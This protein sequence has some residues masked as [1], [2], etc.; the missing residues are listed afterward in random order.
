MPGSETLWIDGTDQTANQDYVMDV[1]AGLAYVT[2][3]ISSESVAKY[4]NYKVDGLY[5]TGINISK[6]GTAQVLTIPGKDT[7]DVL[8]EY[9]SGRLKPIDKDK[10][11]PG[12]TYIVNY[13]TEGEYVSNEPLQI[14]ASTDWVRTSKYPLKYQSVILS[15]NGVYIDE[16]VDFRISY[17]TGRI[18]FFQPLLPG[19]ILVVSYSPLIAH[20]NGL[21]NVYG[22]SYCT[23]YDATVAVASISPIAFEFPNSSVT[24]SAIP[25]SV[26]N[27][28]KAAYYDTTGYAF[29]AGNLQLV[30]DSTN[31]A[32]GTEFSDVVVMSYKFPS[33]GVEYAPVET[34]NFVMNQGS[35]FIALVNQ[36]ST[37]LFPSGT[38]VRLTNVDS[39]GDFYF[40]DA[41]AVYDGEDTLVYFYGTAPSDIINP[42]IYISD[43][44]TVLYISP[45]AVPNPITSG[46][47]DIIF[48]GS[49]IS[50]TF[51]SGQLMT[52]DS[53]IYSI[54]GSEYD[55]SARET[56]VTLGVQTYK[57]YT[58]AGI[59]S[60][61]TIS[62]IPFYTAGDTVI[63]T[64]KSIIVDP[65][66]PV[67]SMTYDG[68]ATVTK[69]A[70]A[71][72][73][74]IGTETHV[75]LDSV[76]LYPIA[77]ASQL[78]S[79]LD[80]T[81]SVT[82]NA[83]F[84]SLSKLVPVNN[85]V[86]TKDSST[87]LSAVPS[88]RINSVDTTDFSIIGGTLVLNNPLVP[89]P[90]YYNLDY[91]GLKPLGDSTV[92]FSGS[93][94]TYLPAKSEVK[95]S[96]QYINLD[97]FY[98][99]VMS[100]RNFLDGVITPKKKEEAN[101]QNGNVGQGGDLPGDEGGLNSTGG[102]AGD[103]Y[104]RV[105]QSIECVVFDKIFDFFNGR[106]QAYGDEFYAALG[107]KIC[108]NDGLLSETDQSAGTLPINRMFPWGDYTNY[109]PYTS[110][111]LTGQTMPYAVS[112]PKRPPTLKTAMATFTPGVTVT[113][114]PPLKTYW[115]HQLKTGDLIRP[116]DSTKNYE[117]ATVNNDSTLILKATTPYDGPTTVVKPFIMTSN[118]PLYDDDGFM[119]A[120]IIGNQTDD[121]GLVSGD[122]FN[123]QV[124]GSNQSYTFQDPPFPIS[125]FFSVDKY[126]PAQIATLLNINLTGIKMSYGWTYD[127][128]SSYGY[129]DAFTIRTADTSNVLI[130]KSG[131]AV[132]KLGFTP[133][134]TAWGNFD[135]T[136]SSAEY[137]LLLKE[138]TDRSSEQVNL[139]T[140]IN[141]PNKMDRTRTDA[142]FGQDL[143]LNTIKPLWNTE[144]NDINLELQRL[145]DET[146]ALNTLLL[147]PTMS[148]YSNS[149]LA[150][151]DATTFIN[152]CTST[153][154]VDQSLVSN[155]QGAMDPYIWALDIAYDSS[156]IP[157]YD[158]T[159]F[160]LNVPVG[161]YDKRVLDAVVN[162]IPYNPDVRY[163]D[164]VSALVDGTWSGYDPASGN[165][166]SQPNSFTF[167]QSDRTDILYL[168]QTD[169]LHTH[170]Y[171][172]D[173]SGL[174]IIW[175]TVNTVSFPYNSLSPYY[176]FNNLRSTINSSGI[177][178]LVA[179]GTPAVNS[180]APGFKPVGTALSPIPISP[181]A[182]VLPALRDINVS[183]KTIDSMYLMD[184]SAFDTTRLLTLADRE[185]F[186]LT[187]ETQ[188][189]SDMTN[190]GYF[191][192]AGN[193]PSNLYVW[194]NNLYNRSNG[195][196]ARLNQIQKQ[197]D[198]DRKAVENSKMF[199]GSASV[200]GVPSGPSQ[201]RQTSGF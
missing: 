145:G 33:E 91:M 152:D 97:Q 58:D 5:D 107:Y 13:H 159:A 113:A 143:I 70:S 124:D 161:V 6:D 39:A 196:W 77:L 21:S 45:S 42:E 55:S 93:Y 135:T 66:A 114:Y 154:L 57:D 110:A 126:T 74:T 199:S 90:N 158:K 83:Y 100:E 68:Y 11:G 133:D 136:H 75:Y 141:Y 198:T 127:P 115:T 56:K 118:L 184:R 2:E 64:S 81:T 80:F 185:A 140:L 99:Q 89:G 163:Y 195:S 43:N 177:P 48:P 101:Q 94:F 35:N 65:L 62:D 167:F 176:N 181:D 134:T 139:A 60:G 128:T 104:R 117:I 186:L 18:V 34:I 138:V 169:N 166:Y 17:L 26:Y 78:N 156:V 73:V 12:E 171:Y 88:L 36:N 19:D 200:P 168:N 125:L 8:F 144:I 16:G 162:S 180:Y 51:R 174:Y 40:R 25:Q 86:V 137:F 32:I 178:S 119:G 106:V 31:L 142:G 84:W 197:I 96:M 194:A 92:S 149:L 47:T 7:D 150:L 61:V 63:S 164:N 1:N 189:R 41:S 24:G 130:L 54:Q 108:N 9:E 76:Y 14:T 191:R 30:S 69:D 187:R 20:K 82:S 190:D 87:V 120:K 121:F 28:T 116:Y 29:S 112:G 193:C 52:L 153:K 175:D 151:G 160:T 103:E 3:L 157:L 105:D 172:V 95:A 22:N 170:A 192:T 50:R 188:I 201:C 179:S 109:A 49:D 38:I 10:P 131:S 132:S 71:L 23:V 102:I 146:D 27:A 173:N 183:F 44:P 59:L 123:V 4:V 122:V 148:G 15:K 79:E 182:T 46:S 129:M 37:S 67:M 111:C 147:E 98:I 53:D 155:Y 85:L 165:T 72:S